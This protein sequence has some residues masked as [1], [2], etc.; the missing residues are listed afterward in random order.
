MSES[1]WKKWECPP[2]MLTIEEGLKTLQL[3]E[4]QSNEMAFSYY[5]TEM[6]KAKTP[7]ERQSWANLLTK[8]K[9]SIIKN[10]LN[11][12]LV[13]DFQLWL[14][15]RSKYNVEYI[16]IP[17][18]KYLTGDKSQTK[19]LC[20]PWGNQ[21]L[22]HLPDVCEWLKLP[23]LNRDKVIKALSVLKMTT[24]LNIE[25][26]WI[27]YKY[28]VRGIGI[29]G[30][31]LKEQ[32]AYNVFDYIE[33]RPEKP[34]KQPDGS[35][36]ME[37]DTEFTP[38]SMENP[39][40]PKFNQI[41]YTKMYNGVDAAARMG[42]LDVLA[43]EDFFSL[44][45]ED[46]LWILAMAQTHTTIL[47]SAPGAG[48]V[49]MP[50]IVASSPVDP[51]YYKSISDA[52][53]QLVQ[54]TRAAGVANTN[55][56]AD[57]TNE[58]KKL[59][60]VIKEL[61]EKVAASGAA[62]GKPPDPVVPGPITVEV[63]NDALIATLEKMSKGFE[64]SKKDYSPGIDKLF[65]EIVDGNKR[66]REEFEKG[67][68]FMGDQMKKLFEH[69]DSMKALAEVIEKT[70]TSP[71]ATK[72]MDDPKK[73][74][75][76]D[77][78]K[79]KITVDP[80][81]VESAI[82]EDKKPD[83]I[84]EKKKEAVV[85]A[86]KETAVKELEILDRTG[87]VIDTKVK[88]LVTTS[89]NMN[90]LDDFM[91]FMKKNNPTAP[92]RAD[93]LKMITTDED[94]MEKIKIQEE[95]FQIMTE[96]SSLFKELVY[97][98]EV[99]NPTLKQSYF[100]AL[101]QLLPSNIIKPGMAQ[102]AMEK[103]QA[104]LAFTNTKNPAV[105]NRG[106]TINQIHHRIASVARNTSR[107]KDEPDKALAHVYDHFIN[108]EYKTQERYEELIK[109]PID[110]TETDT[111]ANIY[112]KIH[113]PVK[114]T[115]VLNPTRTTLAVS[116][117]NGALTA[118]TMEL[119]K[120]NKYNQD[121]E[122]ALER[123]Q[124]ENNVLRDKA[125]QYLSEM[126]SQ[127]MIVAQA[128]ER[129]A[130]ME[131]KVKELESI[132][133]N[134]ATV[135][136]EQTIKLNNEIA[137]MEA[138]IKELESYKEESELKQ[139]QLTEM[140][141]EKR[142]LQLKLAKVENEDVANLSLEKAV[143]EKE[144]EG[145]N[146]LMATIE[147]QREEAKLEYNNTLNRMLAEKAALTNEHKVAAER[148]QFEKNKLQADYEQLVTYEKQN[149]DH[150][151]KEAIDSL[152]RQL[153]LNVQQ[154]NELL[155]YTDAESL[156]QKVTAHL[157]NEKNKSD[158]EISKARESEKN[159]LTKA[160]EAETKYN[161]L[162]EEQ[163]VLTQRIKQMEETNKAEMTKLYNKQVDAETALKQARADG[164]IAY[165]EK[166]SEAREARRMYIDY[167]DKHKKETEELN[168]EMK[169][170]K[171]KRKDLTA[172][173][174]QANSQ[175]R[176]LK[177]ELDEKERTLI[178]Q[179][180][181]QQEK[182]EASATEINRL[183]LL[184]QDENKKNQL[185]R[186]RM[187]AEI[188]KHKNE[189][190]M[191][192][193]Q[194]IGHNELAIAKE[195]ETIGKIDKLAALKRSMKEKVAQLEANNKQQQVN[196]EAKVRTTHK[197]ATEKIRNAELQLKNKEAEMQSETAKTAIEQKR[198]LTELKRQLTAEREKVA[199]L[200]NV[201]QNATKSQQDQ[202]KSLTEEFARHEQKEKELTAQIDR[203]TNTLHNTKSALDVTRNVVA[204]REATIKDSKIREDFITE[205]VAKLKKQIIE[206]EKELGTSEGRSNQF[207]EM[208][209]ERDRQA[210]EREIQDTK[211]STLQNNIISALD[212]LSNGRKSGRLERILQHEGNVDLVNR[213]D[214]VTS[215]LQIGTEILRLQ[216][217]TITTTKEMKRLEKLNE[218][219][220]EE[221]EETFKV[222]DKMVKI[223][224]GF[225]STGTVA[226]KEMNDE[227]ELIMRALDDRISR[228]TEPLSMDE[229]RGFDDKIK[230]LRDRGATF[231]KQSQ[232]ILADVF[233]AKKQNLEI[234][235]N[236]RK[237]N[238][239]GTA[240]SEE[241]F[242]KLNQ[243][244]IQIQRLEHERDYLSTAEKLSK[245]LAI[246]IASASDENGRK[247]LV[248]AKKREIEM[249]RTGYAK[250]QDGKSRD[251]A[252]ELMYE[253]YL[254]A[255]GGRGLAYATA[256][257]PGVRGK[258]IEAFN[259]VMASHQTRNKLGGYRTQG[260]DNL[261]MLTA[262]LEQVHK[263]SP[264]EL[265]RLNAQQGADIKDKR[266]YTEDMEDDIELEEADEGEAENDM[267]ADF[268]I[269]EKRQEDL[270]A[271]YGKIVVE[272]NRGKKK[273]FSEAEEDVVRQ[274]ADIYG[275]K[276]TIQQAHNM[277]RNQAISGIVDTLKRNPGAINTM[278]LQLDRG[279]SFSLDN[280][281]TD[282]GAYYAAAKMNVLFM[283]N[284]KAGQAPPAK[285]MS[286]MSILS[287]MA[288]LEDMNQTT[289][290]VI[291]KLKQKGMNPVYQNSLLKILSKANVF[292]DKFIANDAHADT[293]TLKEFDKNLGDK[294]KLRLA[295]AKEY[296]H[297]NITRSM[298]LPTQQE[299]DRL[300][301]QPTAKV[302]FDA[303]ANQ[304]IDPEKRP[305]IENMVRTRLE[306]LSRVSHITN[307]ASSNILDPY[308][309]KFRRGE[310]E[311]MS[312]LGEVAVDKQEGI[313]NANQAVDFA[314]FY[315]DTLGAKDYKYTRD[316]ID[317]FYTRTTLKRGSPEYE[318]YIKNNMYHEDLN[319]LEGM[320]DS[321]E[322]GFWNASR[323]RIPKNTSEAQKDEH[324]KQWSS[325][326]KEY[327]D[328]Q[329]TTKLFRDTVQTIKTI[330]LRAVQE[331]DINV[332]RLLQQMMTSVIVQSANFQKDIQNTYAGKGRT[333][334]SYNYDKASLGV[335]KKDSILGVYAPGYDPKN[336]K[337][338]L[339]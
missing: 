325:I 257:D 326:N 263:M 261:E 190:D 93:L 87:K 221:K 274:Y 142:L 167:V 310:I 212:D 54:T 242:S 140:N 92:S 200:N 281:Q 182:E 249:E 32:R 146:K 153:Q 213:D 271:R 215:L 210:M 268:A 72:V 269:S 30:N 19:R 82:I 220:K 291:G 331:F 333:S 162:V 313:I 23:I 119:A 80:E 230:A 191:Y 283:D 150:Y 1:G 94:H 99:K 163:T 321:L 112:S 166:V 262:Q 9:A 328:F 148:A 67:N 147:K 21:S 278:Q 327:K 96:Q 250:L 277:L 246:S 170:S 293:D 160:Q 102:Q 319:D 175:A 243:G 8:K 109:R 134:R 22:L 110:R 165:N 143:L 196:M 233:L 292:N 255:A 35:Y 258:M 48:G 39:S 288:Q 272:I 118:K 302:A 88:Q 57:N 208:V 64:D 116:E 77:T 4:Q 62:G 121:L 295:T 42:H 264:Q 98:V 219:Y 58:L 197:E 144:V 201:F 68:R 265:A 204:Q 89:I 229:K 203:L 223:P 56:Q 90:Y 299:I 317:A 115:R 228:P 13:G 26:S 247:A 237:N 117:D 3:T 159:A 55:Q 339:R 156:K 195:D 179:Q 51:L 44:T 216:S 240:E 222:L 103:I 305:G 14:Q 91:E 180:K 301:L 65:A 318:G 306:N 75:E 66:L 253:S 135:T 199:S 332:P 151:Y 330:P 29:D 235:D 139:S 308:V 192:A 128:K 296:Y 41:A 124:I 40:M 120:A 154:K 131:G 81:V 189:A 132:G 316:D 130:L 239:I 217:K 52:I 309:Y 336:K 312:R 34:V 207:L 10:N 46:K 273:K 184:L 205:E 185:E 83:V 294:M 50:T 5:I 186:K 108:K 73:P 241:L 95:E 335:V 7:E 60:D 86:V 176:D 236:L 129:L 194:A 315:T 234:E 181:R 59:R 97:D 289:V 11:E 74:P 238:K 290:E 259:G 114:T 105:F 155:Q 79:V 307:P 337:L 206:K 45:P 16:D 244:K 275:A 152:S 137:K 324:Y 322:K 61:K 161:K 202:K 279:D 104:T 38:L 141:E 267:N 334:S 78:P 187:E 178:A 304:N 171:S 323:K 285:G 84:K 101:V 31:I 33:K 270:A 53:N 126:N 287:K 71:T 198:H 320:F 329:D 6:N 314:N 280:L 232:E 226:L 303:F 286:R 17:N 338:K 36:N 256:M 252:I 49:S 254:E 63:K 266:I 209:G 69:R 168:E 169:D 157:E 174:D 20:T 214:A 227:K 248:E 193:E 100:R 298:G 297:G 158:F 25:E 276:N 37:E 76:E 188:E 311:N 183:T 172:E 111:K 164:S 27:Y 136:E 133:E 284:A 251:A 224:H 125:N 300:P 85:A 127:E 2:D 138:E 43:T 106:Q 24:P 282:P 122:N 47:A 15:G 149:K 107:Y 145:L 113:S 70:S 173:L 12:T 18:I 211:I 28:L 245:D 218:V 177:M 260:Y 231:K 123:S 225:Q